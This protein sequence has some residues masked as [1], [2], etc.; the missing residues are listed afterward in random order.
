MRIHYFFLLLMVS[1]LCVTAFPQTTGK[2]VLVIHGGAGFFK[3]DM[4]DSARQVYLAGINSALDAGEAVLR[5][6]GSS[7]DA[8]EQA[9]RVL[10]DNPAFNAGRG[11]VLNA[12]GH[13]E[14]DASIMNGADLSCGA[15]AAV[16]TVKHPV[17]LARLVKE[18]TP[19]VLLAADGAE[20]FADAMGVE[21]GDSVYFTVPARYDDWKRNTL[22]KQGGNT[23]GAVALD[24]FGN[25]AA[26]TS[27]GG[28]A[29]KMPGR[30]GD[31]PIIGAGTYANNAT[32]AI[33]CTGW[34]ERFIRNAVAFQ[35]SILMELKGMSLADATTTMLNKKLQPNDGGLIAVDAAGNYVMDFNTVG[36]PR[37]VVTSAGERHVFI[38]KEK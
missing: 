27:T 15:V 18:K 17:S 5:N 36:M 29:G 14:M 32:C 3:P 35:V 38:H 4:S 9:V 19:H 23:V 16:K 21:R 12:E 11:A 22:K 37:G 13:V 20:R 30:V 10:E 6:N 24:K 34:G 26:A 25:I 31:S 28:M 2:Y 33:S 7:L 1:S 8:V